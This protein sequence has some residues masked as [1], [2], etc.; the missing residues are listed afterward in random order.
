M[1]YYLAFIRT[2]GQ[3]DGIYRL[4][5]ADSKG[6]ALIKI[7]NEYGTTKFIMITETIK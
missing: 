7:Q 5:Q 2:Y 6:D 4:V 3:D 1:N